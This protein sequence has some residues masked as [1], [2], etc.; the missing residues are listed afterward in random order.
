MVAPI[1]A[2]R[3]SRLGMQATNIRIKMSS[4]ALRKAMICRTMKSRPSFL[5]LP[6]VRYNKMIAPVT[7]RF[8]KASGSIIFQA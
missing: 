6:L 3:S 7:S 4:A 1:S 8:N 5:N 2:D